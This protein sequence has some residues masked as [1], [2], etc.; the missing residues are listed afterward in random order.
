MSSFHEAPPWQNLKG[1]GN[2]SV[3]LFNIF[4]HFNHS[5]SNVFRLGELFIVEKAKYR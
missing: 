3:G 2:F 5:L 1:F 4:Q